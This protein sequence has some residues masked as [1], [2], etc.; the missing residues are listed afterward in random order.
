MDRFGNLERK[1]RVDALRH[2]RNINHTLHMLLTIGTFGLW[3]PV[4]LGLTLAQEGWKHKYCWVTSGKTIKGMTQINRLNVSP[5][6]RN[7]LNKL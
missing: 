3:L 7:M 6:T 5:E 1:S 4:W 2:P